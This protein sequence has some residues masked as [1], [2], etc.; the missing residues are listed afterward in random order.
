[1]NGKEGF[2]PALE[3][4]TNGMT[5]ELA[6]SPDLYGV[7]GW[8]YS[9]QS[10]EE[11]ERPA[12]EAFNRS[13]QLGSLKTDTYFHWA[14][15]EKN[16]AEWMIT[17]ATEGEIT[18]TAI[19][20]QWREC[21][22]V[23]EM[24]IQR[25]GESQL[26]CYWAGY[27]ASRDAKA[28]ERARNFSYAEGAYT[29]SIDWFNKALTAPVSS[30][31]GPVN[32]GAIYRGLTLAFEGLGNEDQLRKSLHNWLAFSESDRY[33]ETELFRL[34]SKFPGLR[35]VPEFVHLMQQSRVYTA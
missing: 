23:A 24:G 20:D 27:A 17:N 18:D 33:I 6:D 28:M 21:E 7:L 31:V 12:R 9:R 15:M 8:L 32:K 34:S 5:G 10:L 3:H 13:H 26:L 22:K 30:D 4:L 25:C 35:S 11:F 1:M 14:L 29:R 2:K 19:A 16:T